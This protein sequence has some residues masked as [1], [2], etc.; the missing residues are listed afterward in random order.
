MEKTMLARSR[1][2]F[3]GTFIAVQKPASSAVNTQVARKKVALYMCAMGSGLASPS[4]VLK[5][6]AAYRYTMVMTTVCQIESLREKSREKKRT[7]GGP[8]RGPLWFRSAK[9]VSPAWASDDE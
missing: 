4:R 6:R 8:C 1:S 3:V 7:T 5:F 9:S 2:F